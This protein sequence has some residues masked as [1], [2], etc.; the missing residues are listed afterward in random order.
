MTEAAETQPQVE[1]TK[2]P[3]RKFISFPTLQTRMFLAASD[4][5]K[6]LQFINPDNVAVPEFTKEELIDLDH[7]GFSLF[8]RA[9]TNE[10]VKTAGVERNNLS[11]AVHDWSINCANII[12]QDPRAK[13]LQKFLGLDPTEMT[14]EKMQEIYAT[15]FTGDNRNSD[16]KSFVQN[17]LNNYRGEGGKLHQEELK[18]DLPSI[19]WFARIF[20]KQS[21]EIVTQLIDA[22]AT[23]INDPDGFVTKGNQERNNL[24][25]KK[26]DKRLLKFLWDNRPTETIQIAQPT[27]EPTASPQTPPE[28]SQP[29]P[30]EKDFEITFLKPEST[31]EI[32][33]ITEK[34][35]EKSTVIQVHPD[36]LPKLDDIK[37][38]FI[39][40]L[41]ELGLKSNFEVWNEL[42]IDGE[43]IEVLGPIDLSGI[44]DERDQYLYQ[45][46]R[47][48]NLDGTT[49]YTCL[50]LRKSHLNQA[51]ECIA[52]VDFTK[53]QNGVEAN[54][55]TNQLTQIMPVVELRKSFGI[56]KWDNMIEAVKVDDNFRGKGFGRTIWYLALS[57]AGLDG[58]NRVNIIGDLTRGQR[59]D[60]PGESFYENLGSEPIILFQDVN[61]EISST[62][63][64]Y[65]PTYMLAAQ[66]NELRKLFQIEEKD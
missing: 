47:K 4:M 66:R 20:G 48:K 25:G 59:P 33:E 57:Q 5:Q 61:G 49:Q 53:L 43:N 1:R 17:M 9:S 54:C 51:N 62:T 46:F 30:T 24:K 8:N 18:K 32:I 40:Y 39:P 65:T 11:P 56:D 6:N 60:K 64:L 16:V 14:A 50:L 3:E 23:L 26:H 42:K 41:E 36:Q 10:R 28:P 55:G 37:F 29:E 7:Q 12:R 44:S 63:H 22:E 38:K 34:E 58:T 21:A 2:T 13:T 45:A 15:Y 31:A 19:Q 27:Q 52:H 35:P